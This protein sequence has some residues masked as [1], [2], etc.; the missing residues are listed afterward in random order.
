VRFGAVLVFAVG[1]GQQHVQVFNTNE[2]ELVE[3]VIKETRK[4]PKAV[5]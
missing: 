2:S 1:D 3:V 5:K 4:L